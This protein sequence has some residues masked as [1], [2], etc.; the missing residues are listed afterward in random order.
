LNLNG[1]AIRSNAL[2][3]SIVLD[4][5]LTVKMFVAQNLLFKE[6]FSIKKCGLKY[7]STKTYLSAFLKDVAV[8]LVVVARGSGL[9]EHVRNVERRLV[10]LFNIN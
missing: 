7:L 5:N 10:Q 6:N 9:G 2:L 4:K 3:F 8:S 1:E